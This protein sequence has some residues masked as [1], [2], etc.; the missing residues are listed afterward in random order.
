MEGRNALRQPTSVM[1]RQTATLATLLSLLVASCGA[2]HSGQNV[3]NNASHTAG[4][5]SMPQRKFDIHDNASLLF[6]HEAAPAERHL[7]TALISAY[8]AAAAKGDGRKA[9]PMLHSWTVQALLDENGGQEASRRATCP[10]V[11]S[12]LFRQE[13]HRMAIDHATLEIVGV[14]IRGRR[15]LVILRF[16]KASLPDQMGVRIQGGHW[17][18]W[19]LLDSHIP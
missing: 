11:L 14:R 18:I 8:Y 1:K 7:I 13:H 19:D 3:T 6:G 2:T 5:S 4:A 16:E 12:K 9:C 17:K 15:A 10:V